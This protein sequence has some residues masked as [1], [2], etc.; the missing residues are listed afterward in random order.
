MFTNI[1]GKI[2]TLAKVIC[3]VGIVASVIS[4]IFSIIAGIASAENS[5]FITLAAGILTMVMGSLGAWIGSFITYGFGE[6]V[7]NV[8]RISDK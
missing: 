5:T 1:G 6:I 8:K 3:W 7:D 2:K 4:G